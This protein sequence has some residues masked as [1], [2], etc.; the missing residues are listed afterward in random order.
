MTALERATTIVTGRGFRGASS[1][2][3][4][5]RIAEAFAWAD[6]LADAARIH[7]ENGTCDSVAGASETCRDLTNDADGWCSHCDFTLAVEGITEARS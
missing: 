7:C 1:E 4:A 6:Q 2:E 5:R 3:Q